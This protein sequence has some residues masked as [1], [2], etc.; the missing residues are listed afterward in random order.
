MHPVSLFKE[1]L[2]GRGLLCSRKSPFLRSGHHSG[3]AAA[4]GI[5]RDCKVGNS[6]SPSLSSPLL[7]NSVDQSP[8]EIAAPPPS[9]LLASFI[10]SSFVVFQPCPT[11]QGVDG[12]TTAL[13]HNPIP[14]L[15]RLFLL[16][17]LPSLTDIFRVFY[18][19]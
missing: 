19:T 18:K 3:S 9:M 8:I 1:N 15:C 16:Y 10:S 13:G 5:E 17:Q 7:L 11:L 12:S 2:G 14:N 6:I 4:I